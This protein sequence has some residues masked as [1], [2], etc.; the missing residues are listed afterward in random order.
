MEEK[1]ETLRSLALKEIDR[2]KWIPQSGYNRIR[3]MVENRPDW[4]ISRQRV[5]GV[6]I[7]VFYCKNCGEI[8]ANK[9][10]FEHIAQLFENYE[11]GA[12]LWFEKSAEELLP[13]G[14]KCPKCGGSEFEKEEDILDVWFDSGSSHAA[15]LKR[16]GIP[17][18]DMYLE[19]SDQH[20]G[21]FQSSLLEGVASYGEA[22][23]RSVLTHGFTLDE[24]GRKMS[25]SL[26]NVVAPQEVIDRYG[27]DILRLWTVSE[28]YTEDI[29]IGDKVLKAIAEDYRKIRNTL[30]F[31]LGNLYDFNP[32]RDALKRE[33][34]LE[35]DRW[36]L[37]YLQGVVE[38]IHNFYR[39][40]QFYRAFGR[41][42]SFI[43]RELSAVYLDVLKD[44]LYVYSPNSR[45]RR[46]AQTVLWELLTALTTLIAPVLS[47]TAEEAWQVIRNSIK[48]DLPESV[49][50][51]LMYQ[52]KEEYR[53]KQLE[54]VYALLLKLREDVNRALEL[55]RRQ[56]LIRHPY[57]AKVYLELPEELKDIVLPRRDYL[58]YFLTVSQVEIGTA[59]G[60]VVLEGEEIKGLKVGVSPAEG[61][62]C[63]RCWIYF[64]SEEFKTLP[65]GQRVC[66][67]CYKA[68]QEMGFVG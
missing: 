31:L 58:P 35:F 53:D 5:W 29:K 64:P 27:A 47:F 32:D 45:E 50:L 41:L 55:A 2:V 39:Q 52:P 60:E 28:D 7:T 36:M 21:W 40:Y 67:R 59:Q 33:E 51:S 22:P 8:I 54:E 38:E 44:R 12:D 24:K 14:Y 30:R 66:Q 17:K 9:E 37:S 43:N 20:R 42:K 18:A 56:K 13:E 23:Y 3:S 57:E 25:K 6:P 10:I 62:K 15:V 19:G 65:D 48:G 11:Y 46:S 63:P 1:K 16:R 26:G 49:F 34:L 61:E 68:L 4:C